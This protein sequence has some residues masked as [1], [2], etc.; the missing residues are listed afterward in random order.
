MIISKSG[1]SF[2]S[3]NLLLRTLQLTSDHHYHWKAK[4]RIVTM[5]WYQHYSQAASPYPITYSHTTQDYAIQ[6]YH[7]AWYGY[8]FPQHHAGPQPRPAAPIPHIST[9]PVQQAAPAPAPAVNT[10]PTSS[11]F[12]AYTPTIARETT[13]TA[14]TSSGSSGGRGP[15]RHQLK[16]L[17]AKECTYACFSVHSRGQG[18]QLYSFGFTS[19]EYLPSISLVAQR[20]H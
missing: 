18:R 9:L 5:S 2:S 6:Q 8:T 10:A 20:T 11:T 1:F 12:S 19:L 4:T 7:Q 15:R 3:L 16:G 14:N 13:L 17:F